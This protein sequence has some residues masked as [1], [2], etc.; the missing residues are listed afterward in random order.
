MSTEQAQGKEV[1]HRTDIFSLGVLM[2]EALTGKRPFTGENNAELI[3]NLLKTEPRKVSDVRSG[4]P[5]EVSR[6]IGRCMGKRP[7][8]RPQSM[9]EVRSIL[10]DAR[11]SFRTGTSTT[12]SFA[13]RLYRESSSVG[14]WLRIIPVGLVIALAAVAWFY[15]SRS[16]PSSPFSIDT[17]SMRK[18]SQSNNVALSVVSPDGGSV[19]YVTYEDDGGRALW[20]R[21]VNDATA[22]KIVPPQQV[23]Y[24]DIGFSDDNEY[25]YFITAPRFGVHGTLFRVPAL[26]GKPR[27]ISEKTNHLGNQSSDGRRIL[28]VRYGDPAPDTS[29]NVIDSKLISAN[30]EDGTDERVLKL[31]KGES[32]I[33]KA[34]YSSDG[35]T[36]FYIKRELKEIEYWSIVMLNVETGAEREIIRGR[37]LIEFLAVLQDGSGLLINAV[38]GASNRRQLFHVTV[39]GGLVTRITNDLNNYIGVSVDREGRNIVTVQRTDESRVWVGEAGNFTAMTPITREPLA[40]QSVDWTPDGRLVFDVL[41]NNQLSIWIANADGKDALQLSPQDSDNYNPRVSGDG[42]YVVFTSKRAGYNQVWRMDIDGSNAKLLADAPGI[43]QSPQFAADGETIVFRWYN[44]GAAPMGQVSVD[45]GPVT[46]LDYLPKA[47]TYL[48]AMSPDQ[49]FVAYSTGGDA[50]EPMRVLVRDVN[51]LVPKADLDIRPISIFKWMHDGRRI[52]YKESQKGEDLE[53]KIFEIDPEKGEPKLLLTTGRDSISDLTFSRDGKRFAV[54][55]SNT[56]TD[57]VMLTAGLGPEI[58]P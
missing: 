25:V 56:L 9:Q 49:K 6:L 36:V 50:S 43:T 35:R 27:K 18:L 44:E 14:L 12:G 22:I 48:W 16:S 29:V 15:F 55:R 33:R 45:G 51:S 40:M 1:D 17:M 52:F 23:H 37:D 47:F 7:A 5:V 26:G 20:L 24:W 21:R 10:E 2:Y 4:V 3:S 31:L 41:R 30:S 28:F 32:I 13:R 46:G 38:D 39:S 54:V 34:R 58:K 8:D 53:S 57:S 19:A 42:R 11:K